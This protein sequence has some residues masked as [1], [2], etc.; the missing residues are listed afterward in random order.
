MHVFWST[1]KMGLGAHIIIIH[2]PLKGPLGAS[3]LNERCMTSNDLTEKSNPTVFCIYFV[4]LHYTD[5]MSCKNLP[6]KRF[7]STKRAVGCCHLEERPRQDQKCCTP[8]WL[9]ARLAGFTLLRFDV[10]PPSDR[11][12]AD[13]TGAQRSTVCLRSLHARSTCRM[14]VG[15]VPCCADASLSGCLCW[16]DVSGFIFLFLLNYTPNFIN[17]PNHVCSYPAQIKWLIGK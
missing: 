1:S 2:C 17:L 10:L 16:I 7:W 15:P 13:L 11:V 3:Y 9:A 14:S 4:L 6:P 5:L 12:P 8:G